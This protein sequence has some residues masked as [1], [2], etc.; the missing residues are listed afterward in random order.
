MFG[1]GDPLALVQGQLV[2]QSCWGGIRTHDL[3]VMSPTSC[4][5]ST[6][7]FDYSQALL[8]PNRTGR[9]MVGAGLVPPAVTQ[10]G[11]RFEAAPSLP[12]PAWRGR[13]QL[14]IFAAAL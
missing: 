10:P 3:R 2:K 14:F 4:H 8:R 11:R 13:R 12:S 1:E 9:R 6:Q 7:R 5:C